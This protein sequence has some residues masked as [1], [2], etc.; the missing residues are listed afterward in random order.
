MRERH[1][2][3][4]NGFGAYSLP[5][6]EYL[7]QTP[8]S[9][10]TGITNALGINYSTANR[11]VRA[12]SEAG[13]LENIKGTARNRVYAYSPYLDLFNENEIK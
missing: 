1:R 12:F 11:L 10:V 8:I 6:L 5:L 13:I 7:Y 9:N 2:E 3:S 4:V